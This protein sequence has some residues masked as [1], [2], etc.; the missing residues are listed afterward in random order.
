M[1]GTLLVSYSLEQL[2]EILQRKGFKASFPRGEARGVLD[3]QSAVDAY[4]VEYYTHNFDGRRVKASGLL[5]IPSPHPRAYPFLAYHHGT[6]IHKKGAPSYPEN[7]P[8]SQF[9]AVMF[10][11]HGYVVGL[12]DYIGL[13]HS[14]LRH[15]Y[16]HTPTEAGAAL[17]MLKAAYD[18][19]G[20]LGARL[21]SQLF[22]TGYSQ[23]GQVTL[24]LQQL[25]EKEYPREFPLTASAP[26]SGPYD[27]VSLWEAAVRRPY[28]LANSLLC[29]LAV[30]YHHI[31][32]P[33][34]DYEDLFL[35]PY[36]QTAPH[37]V[38]GEV[39]SLAEEFF[40]PTPQKLFQPVFLAQVKRRR[41]RLYRKL[42]EN[43]LKPWA[44]T[45][46]TCFYY[47]LDDEVVT[48]NQAEWMYRQCLQAGG[49][50][51]LKHCGK[52]RHLNAYLPMMLTIRQW[53]DRMKKNSD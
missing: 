19:C 27:L 37:L 47:S 7:C 20:Q 50:V 28:P 26:G 5:L 39:N 33:E 30:D 32:R 1:N 52:L 17:D 38:G 34:G 43:S 14:Q 29:Y 31:Y 51:R 23:G 44:A 49:D 22:L 11:A 4:L 45:T 21:N 13:G 15:P 12:P 46:P 8:E 16:F 25:L 18:L 48:R 2:R 53:F 9:M 24:A 35:P 3:P 41:H 6:I 40:P 10:A 36:H 42:K